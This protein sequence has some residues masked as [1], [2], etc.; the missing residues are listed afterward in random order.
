M[1]SPSTKTKAKKGRLSVY[2]KLRCASS[3]SEQMEI[4]GFIPKGTT[5]LS[6]MISI[7]KKKK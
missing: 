7:G 3:F 2:D 5:N 6:G 1:P 4:L